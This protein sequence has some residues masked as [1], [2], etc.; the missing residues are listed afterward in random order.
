[1][2]A[3]S[4]VLRSQAHFLPLSK[5]C[6]RERGSEMARQSLGKYERLKECKGEKEDN[7]NTREKIK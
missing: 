3:S 2:F 5:E 1:M 7:E 6:E 4:N